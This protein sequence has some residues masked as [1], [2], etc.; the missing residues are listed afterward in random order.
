[1]FIESPEPD[2]ARWSRAAE[3]SADRAGLLVCRDLAG[4]CRAIS[5]Q[6]LGPGRP[7]T[8]ERIDNLVRWNVSD[9]YFA[10]AALAG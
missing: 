8:E 9:D 10:L 5:A 1:L 2:V 6:A 3:L 4:A 7:T